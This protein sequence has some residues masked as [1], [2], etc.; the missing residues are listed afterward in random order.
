MIKLDLNVLKR[1]KLFVATPMYGGQCT[2]QYMQSM[3]SLSKM[4]VKNGISVT[5]CFL[6]NESL[7]TRARNICVDAFLKS[8]CTHML[9]IDS[10]IKFNPKDA[11]ALLQVADTI[12]GYDIVTGPYSKKTIPGEYAFNLVDNNS[13]DQNS[14]VEVAEAAT[15]FMIITREALLKYAKFYPELQYTSDQPDVA[16]G[17]MFA[18][19]DTMIDAETN[20][21]LSE[22]Y[23]F[24]K[25]ARN[26]GIKVWMCPW[27]KLGHI[28][29]YEY[30]VE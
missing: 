20:R 23:M 4:C 29:S 19:F 1:K 6:M 9:F 11:L 7:V 24:S 27:I 21:Y 14:I 8:D 13:L 5:E 25:Y 3:L 15:G 2:G 28:G 10:D 17:D 12:K 30:T 26:I 18:F 22:D 16:E